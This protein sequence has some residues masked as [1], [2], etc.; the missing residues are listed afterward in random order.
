MKL[1]I[2][3]LKILADTDDGNA[4]AI[5]GSWLEHHRW[6]VLWAQAL[7]LPLSEEQ[8]N[9]YTRNPVSI[10][11]HKPSSYTL[12]VEPGVAHTNETLAL[13]KARDAKGEQ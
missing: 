6:S 12:Y 10:V 3:T 7:E 11:S 1:S 5:Y 13:I 9:T 2:D 8:L 4:K